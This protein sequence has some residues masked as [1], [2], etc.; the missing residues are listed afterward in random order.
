MRAFLATV[1]T[2]IAM[3]VLLI[4]YGLLAPRADAAAFT[5]QFARPALVNDR[6]RSR[7]S[8]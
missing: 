3:G 1:L 8:T 7:P 4:A 5:D 6:V 2:V